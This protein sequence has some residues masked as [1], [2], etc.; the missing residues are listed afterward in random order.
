MMAPRIRRAREE[1]VRLATLLRSGHPESAGTELAISD[2]FW[3]E[4]L[5]QREL[6]IPWG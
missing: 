6:S 1:P 4:I 5:I 3:E 2:W